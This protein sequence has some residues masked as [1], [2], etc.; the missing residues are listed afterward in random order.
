MK[1]DTKIVKK[2]DGSRYSKMIKKGG[3]DIIAFLHQAIE[4]KSFWTILRLL[5]RTLCLG[6]S[7]P[8]GFILKKLDI[9]NKKGKTKGFNF[10]NFG[11]H[12]MKAWGEGMIKIVR[13]DVKVYFEQPLL[14]NKTYLF[15]SNHTSP[16]DIAILSASCCRMSSL[17]FIGRFLRQYSIPIKLNRKPKGA[18]KSR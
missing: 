14:P 2:K 12:Q 1:A 3:F 7:I 11:F 18:N 10:K 9:S 8:F 16:F 15:A 17:S 13:A 5:L 6:W 4:E